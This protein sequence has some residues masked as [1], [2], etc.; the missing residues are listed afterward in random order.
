MKEPRK[1][2]LSEAVAGVIST[3][4]KMMLGLLRA[5]GLRGLLELAALFSFVFEL[6]R[7]AKEF[8]TLFEAFK[9]GARPPVAPPPE[10]VLPPPQPRLASASSAPPRIRTA[11]R[12]R[13]KRPPAPQP[14]PR[15]SHARPRPAAAIPRL[16]PSLC[17]VRAAPIRKNPAVAARENRRQ[18]HYDIVSNI[19]QLTKIPHLS[20]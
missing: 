7:L 2:H 10:P 19:I 5:R 4:V 1:Q 17:V 14:R 13:A 8:A 9:A 12:P 6:R 18:F 16:P 11:A 3:I 20:P 15:R